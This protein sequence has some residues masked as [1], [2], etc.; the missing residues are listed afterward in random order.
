MIEMVFLEATKI[1]LKLNSGFWQQ[2][3]CLK[4]IVFGYYQNYVGQHII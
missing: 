4:G 3:C 1:I 2:L